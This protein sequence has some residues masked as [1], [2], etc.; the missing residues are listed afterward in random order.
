[1]ESLAQTGDPGVDD[2]DSSDAKAPCASSIT[3][4][5]RSASEREG[6][7]KLPPELLLLVAKSLGTQD[8]RNFRLVSRQLEPIAAGVLFFTIAV[9]IS[10]D[11]SAVRA[12]PLLNSKLSGS[13]HEV[14]FNFYLPPSIPLTEV[15]D[16]AFRL[17]IRQYKIVRQLTKLLSCSLDTAVRSALY[18]V[19]RVS[20]AH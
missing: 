13:A 1:M 9:T 6:L 16:F 10:S 7:E 11:R 20:K 8:L 4:P 17:F 5:S 14:R 18:I 19:F 15:R 2:T 3:I 12:I